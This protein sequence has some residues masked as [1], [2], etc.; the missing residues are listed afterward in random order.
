MSLPEKIKIVEVG[1]RDGLQNISQTLSPNIRAKLVMKLVD[2]GVEHV[3]VGSFV[4]PQR[5]PQMTGADEVFSFLKRKPDVIYSALTPNL[6]GMEDAIAAGATEV[7]VFGSASEGFSQHNINCS[8]AESFQRFLPVIEMA[9]KEGIP[10]RGYVS[11]VMGCPYDGAVSPSQVTAVSRDLVQMG[12]YEVSLGD[13]LGIGTFFETKKLIEAVRKSVPVEQI[14]AHFHNTYG[15]ALLNLYAAIEEGVA[16]VDTSI[17]GLGGCPYAPGARGNVATED[18]VYMLD[19][20]G[21]NSGINR[22]K[23]TDVSSYISKILNI[24][25]I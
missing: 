9:L 16:V 10:V 13:T 8:I 6:R 11:C 22:Q 20:M 15:Q 23:L 24:N 21:V 7:A 5:V 25:Q 3:E 17:A 18:V 4:S 12:C 19:G 2:A 1:P 14:A